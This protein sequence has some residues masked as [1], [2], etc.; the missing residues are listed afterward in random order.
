MSAVFRMIGK[1][2]LF[3]GLVILGATFVMYTLLWAAPGDLRDVLCPK[4]CSAER[5]AEIAKEWGLEQPLLVQYGRWLSKAVRFDFGYS[6]SFSQGA[7]IAGLLRRASLLTSALVFGA[8]I[9][10]LLLAFFLVWRPVQRWLRWIARLGQIPLSLLSFVP[11]Y[12]LAYWLVMASGRLPLWLTEVGWLSTQTR[13]H[14]LNIGLLPFGQ[15]LEW[16]AELGWLFLVPFFLSM[17]LLA[18]GNNNLVE[19]SSGVRAEWEHIKQ[20]HFMRAVRARGASWWYHLLVNMMLPTT[21]FFTTRAIL[22][23]GTVVIIES[24]MGITGIGWLLW[25]ATQRRDTPLVLAIALFATVLSCL[26]QMLN[27]IALQLIDPRLRK[28]G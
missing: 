7:P 25:E 3:Y 4:G 14:W 22:L 11:L 6:V 28:D 16:T 21:Q 19:Q 15:E 27:E 20:Q 23:L 9:L 8:A 26:L 18:L 13:Q 17:L 5:K 2:V 24:I 12:I 1:T 10:T